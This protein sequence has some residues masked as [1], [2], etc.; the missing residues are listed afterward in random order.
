MLYQRFL[1]SATA[2]NI[3]AASSIIEVDEIF[4]AESFKGKRLYP[5]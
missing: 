4:L 5:T 3:N 2:L 1:S